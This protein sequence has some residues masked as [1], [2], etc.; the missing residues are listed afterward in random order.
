MSSYRCIN[1]CSSWIISGDPRS[2]RPPLRF[3]TMP[4]AVPVSM[5][6]CPLNTLA[7]QCCSHEGKSCSLVS[8]SRTQTHMQMQG[9][10]NSYWYFKHTLINQDIT[11]YCIPLSTE[12]HGISPF[13]DDAKD[14]SITLLACDIAKERVSVIPA[15]GLRFLPQ[16]SGGLL[17]YPE[18]RE[19]AGQKNTGS[20]CSLWMPYFLLRA[21][22]LTANVK[23]D[24]KI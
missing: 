8:R 6:T 17:N 14:M 23:K 11:R 3:V 5:V 1:Y 20:T 21:P 16:D 9:G 24:I 7:H 12:E 2:T 18:L 13:P 22:D 19:T 15:T 4:M 10:K